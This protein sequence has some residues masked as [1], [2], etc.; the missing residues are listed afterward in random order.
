MFVSSSVDKVARIVS[1]TYNGLVNEVASNV[2]SIIGVKFEQRRAPTG[3]IR[4]AT[5]DVR[6]DFSAWEHPELQWVFKGEHPHTTT[7]RVESS[8]ELAGCAL[9]SAATTVGESAVGTDVRSGEIGGWEGAGIAGVQGDVGTGNII[10][11]L[12]DI[13]FAVGVCLVVDCPAL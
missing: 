12:H 2:T 1:I 9:D 7:G 8:S 5:G 11:G 6:W 3:R 4:A 13:N 10:I